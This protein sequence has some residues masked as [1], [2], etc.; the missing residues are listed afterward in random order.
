M[1]RSL[2]TVATLLAGLGAAGCAVDAPSER[3]ERAAD[4]AAGLAA[5]AGCA[6]C[7]W[8]QPIRGSAEPQRLEQ[9]AR[10]AVDAQGNVLVGG[11]FEG[12]LRIGGETLVSAGD[13]DVF[14]ARLSP[15]GAVLWARRFGGAGNEEL[16]ALALD[17]AG[18]ALVTGN[19]NGTLA[20][21]GA[22]LTG[23]GWAMFLAKL[24]PAG[25]A[26]WSKA[27]EGEESIQGA[28]AIAADRQGNVL[29]AGNLEGTLDFGGLTVDHGGVFPFVVKLSPEGAPR[30]AKS[31]KCSVDQE[32]THL[33]ADQAGNVRFAG[34]V[35]HTCVDGIS[36]RGRAFNNIL[37]GSIESGGRLGWVQLVGNETDS[38][39]EGMD[40]D[41][42][43]RM[44]AAV[45]IEGAVEMSGMQL[46]GP[47]GDLTSFAVQ[48]DPRGRG[49]WA[50][51]L[52]FDAAGVAVMPS[53]ESVVAGTLAQPTT[54]GEVDEEVAA[55]RLG[56]NGALRWTFHAGGPG[57][58][59]ALGVALHGQ[60]RAVVLASSD[61]A[62]DLGCGPQAGGGGPQLAVAG[63]DLRERCAE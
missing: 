53:G 42:A 43:G 56:N 62:L 54:A 48:L 63:L 55:A 61:G 29:L 6:G 25:N 52:T 39:L 18:N 47:P 44:V 4:A 13:S 16:R 32:I 34:N 49:R 59:G 46:E 2:G 28:T 36:L 37:V 50:T 1:R 40:V 30:W 22:T 57:D 58:Q 38:Y 27:L 5:Q 14:L 21:G 33:A 17:P 7:A 10:L 24:D 26:I 31:F 9:S 51:A 19:F 3:S 12:S 8:V 35:K 45:K 11:T 15:A 60:R 23:A 20:M 41:R